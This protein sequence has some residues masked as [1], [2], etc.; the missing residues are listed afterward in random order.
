MPKKSFN[1]VLLAGLLGV[2]T[3]GT[4]FIVSVCNVSFGDRDIWWTHRGMRVTMEETRNEFELFIAGKP[5]KKH[6]A[7]GTL[8]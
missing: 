4:S 5:L 2:F 7:S 8:F 6:L 3:V 1:P